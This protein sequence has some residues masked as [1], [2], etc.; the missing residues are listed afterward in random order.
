MK[1][2]ISRKFFFSFMMILGC[3]AFSCPWCN[4]DIAA[5][6]NTGL[7][8]QPTPSPIQHTTPTQW[9][10]YKQVD[11][12]RFEPTKSWTQFS[13]EKMKNLLK[14]V[15]HVEENSGGGKIGVYYYPTDLK[16]EDLRGY[17][18]KNHLLKP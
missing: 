17:L 8:D 10:G 5:M 2:F 11:I 9:T 6:T 15:T 7:T 16:T 13:A 18:E 14:G 1:L 3:N 12:F 4:P